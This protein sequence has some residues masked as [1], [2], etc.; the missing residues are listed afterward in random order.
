MFTLR[1]ISNDYKHLTNE[2]ES[3]THTHI[4]PNSLDGASISSSFHFQLTLAAFGASIF[5]SGSATCF[6]LHC[7]S[8]SAVDTGSSPTMDAHKKLSN[9]LITFLRILKFSA[10][11]I[12]LSLDFGLKMM[13]NLCQELPWVMTSN[14]FAKN[15]GRKW[16]L[17]LRKKKLILK[18]PNNI[19]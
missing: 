18:F 19:H 3:H 9:K 5:N 10:Y 13:M 4:F 6:T 14:K 17:K 7:F 12:C 8:E 16:G 15:K 11:M 1:T 2:H